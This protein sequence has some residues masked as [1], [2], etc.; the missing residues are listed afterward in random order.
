[1]VLEF[2]AR[3]SEWDTPDSFNGGE[4]AA[5]MTVALRLAEG[6]RRGGSSL[7]AGDPRGQTKGALAFA[8]FM[9]AN[10]SGKPEERLA[11]IR[12]L[13]FDPEFKESGPRLLSLLR[14][15]DGSGWSQMAFHSAA[16]EA[17]NEAN[18][19]QLGAE[20]LR[21]WPE[22]TPVLRAKTTD[23][24][25]KRPERVRALLAVIEK[26]AVQPEELSIAQQAQ[27]R[28]HR[29]AAIREQAVKVLGRPPTPER[30]SVIEAF[31][32]ALSL[33]GDA[34]NGRKI[35]QARCATCHKLGSDGHTLGPD[36]ATV[37]SGGKEKLLVAILDP[38]REVAPN[39]LGYAIETKDGESLSGVL[40]SENA[41][42]V[43]LRMAGG[44][45]SVIARANIASLQSQGRS[46][47]P[48][49]LEEGLKPQDMADLLEFIVTGP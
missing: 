5:G 7:K 19:P 26:G 47:M 41:N 15:Q 9:A 12:L 35:F 36:L 48:E 18:W 29:D 49:G 16:S 23:L 42:S 34:S 30:Q 27:L 14:P 40:A 33:K 13:G 25:L 20:L 4:L 11:A 17:L 32:P 46:L 44:V 45:E 39:F 43:T 2:I 3:K 21:L 37:K 6:L 38:N 24:L 22:L 31:Q 10:H 1:M 8:R 28:S